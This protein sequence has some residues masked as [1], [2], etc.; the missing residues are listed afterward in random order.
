M[1]LKEGLSD[2]TREMSRKPSSSSSS[3]PYELA[4]EAAEVEETTVEAAAG[5][6]RS[7]ASLTPDQ[8]VFFNRQLAS[9][10]K[11]DLPIAKGMKAL[12]QEAANPVFREVV[13]SV[14]RDLEQGV[15]LTDALAKFPH[16]FPPLY[17][18]MLRA[19][20]STGN[21]S[22]ALEQL[23]AYSEAMGNIR[24]RLVTA[25]TYPLFT[26]SLCV[27]GGFFFLVFVVPRFQMLVEELAM[28]RI[29]EAGA[30]LPLVTR[31]VFVLSGLVRQ[32]QVSVPVLGGLVLVVYLVARSLRRSGRELDQV[33]FR[34]PVFG[35]LFQKVVLA[36]FCRTLGEL[37]RSG[38]SMV[39]G[40]SLVAGVTGNNAIRRAVQG[41]KKSVENGDRMTAHLDEARLFP[42]SMVWR[43]RMA[44][45]RGTVEHALLEMAKQYEADVEV[46]AARIAEVLAPT[47]IIAVAGLVVALLLSVY[48]P[49]AWFPTPG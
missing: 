17:I 19:G 23:A 11:L 31:F 38:V 14:R 40:L 36:R 33:V 49:L 34:L 1:K 44:E 3:C 37:L 18:E 2:I 25:I 5:P 29:E 10:L 32:W 7:K 8:M 13:E 12:S 4:E 48:L 27:A 47:F 15:S 39:Q 28:T 16:S 21:L 24:R 30:N 26:A 41:M 43:L 46:N 6:K 20:E 22:A 42:P 45:E 35:G 9:M